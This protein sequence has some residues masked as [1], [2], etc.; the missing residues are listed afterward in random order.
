L[1]L[2]AMIFFPWL[3]TIFMRVLTAMSTV[4]YTLDNISKAR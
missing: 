4:Y 2:V 1:P 3:S